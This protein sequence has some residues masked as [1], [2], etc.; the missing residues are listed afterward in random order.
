MSK[1]KSDRPRLRV[2]MRVRR[3]ALRMALGSTAGKQKFATGGLV[4]AIGSGIWYLIVVALPM[5]EGV[6]VAVTAMGIGLATYAGLLVSNRLLSNELEQA[7]MAQGLCPHCGIDVHGD[8]SQTC[9]KCGWQHKEKDAE[10][11]A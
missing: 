1:T 2:S 7:V 4:A 6:S 8:F 11:P 3:K 10:Q 9:T 5:E